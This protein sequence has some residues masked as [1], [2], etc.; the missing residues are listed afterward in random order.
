M[1]FN[2][3]Y[4]DPYDSML[5]QMVLGLIG[6]CFAGAFYW[7]SRSFRYEGEDRFLRVSAVDA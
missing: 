6:L 3:A 5:G 7:L 4:L 2:R 1:L